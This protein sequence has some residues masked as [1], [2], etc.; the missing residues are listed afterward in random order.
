MDSMSD[1]GKLKALDANAPDAMRAFWAFDK[2]AMAEG[3]I[4]RKFRN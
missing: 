2:A 1:L 3:V 4:P